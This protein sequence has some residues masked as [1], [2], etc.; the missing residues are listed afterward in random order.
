T[1]EEIKK[2]ERLFTHFIEGLVKYAPKDYDEGLGTVYERYVMDKYLRGIKRKYEISSVLEGPSDGIT[3]I[4]GINS[5]PFAEEGANVTYLTPSTNEIAYVSKAL[6]DLNSNAKIEI[7]KGGPLKFPFKDNTFD[8]TWNFC[9]IEHFMNPYP[10]V[11]EMARVSGKYVLLMNQNKYNVGT[12]PHILYHKLKKQEWDHGSLK[13]MSV[14]G[15]KKLARH[16]NLEVLEKGVID[17]PLWP[18]TWDMP[19]RGIFKRVVGRFGKKWEWS[20][21]TTLKKK[22]HIPPA[23]KFFEKVENLP[24]P[25]FVKL[26]ITHHLYLLCKK[27]E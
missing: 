5:L 10:L 13:W 25:D 18:D 11:E 21:M 8:L 12:Y 14:A 20:T 15:L 4:R 23:L 24:V 7:K 22:E 16:A 2:D 19:V 17:V 27:I 26:P 3:G 1:A 9:I 6:K